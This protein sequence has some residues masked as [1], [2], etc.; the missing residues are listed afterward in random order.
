MGPA[1][2]IVN[3]G[4]PERE[5]AKPAM[6]RPPRIKRISMSSALLALIQL[7]EWHEAAALSRL[8]VCERPDCVDNFAAE[9]YSRVLLIPVSPPPEEFWAL[10][11]TQTQVESGR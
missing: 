6:R 1:F 10:V 8:G 7:G 9:K 11:S 4:Y 2:T 3:T 5:R